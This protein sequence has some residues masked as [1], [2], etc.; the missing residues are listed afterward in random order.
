MGMAFAFGWT[1]CIGPVL[2]AVL[3]LASDTHTLA[4]GEA[5]LVAYSLGLGVPFV[6]LGVAFGRLAGV[7]AFVRAHL[8]IINLVSGLL[9]AGLGILLVTG[10]VARAVQLGIGRPR[11]HRPRQPPHRLKPQ[12]ANGESPRALATVLAALMDLTIHFRNAVALVGRF[13]VLAGVDLDVA[14]GE[15]VLLQ[16]ANGAGKTSLLRACA[17]LLRV[18]AGEAVVLGEDLVRDPR[19]VRRRVGLLGPRHRPLRRPAPGRQPAVRRC[20]P[21]GASAGR[22]RPPW[23]GWASRGGWRRPLSA[24]C[25]PG[26]AGGWPS[27]RWSLA[28]RS[29]GCS[30]SRTPA[31]TPSTGTCWTG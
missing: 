8:R 24:R 12:V 31:S 20:G 5:M 4:R 2:A 16:G 30:T 19:A 7:L 6:A 23:S 22:S 1:P 28:T 29:C 15:I 21:P 3:G 25:P 14:R 10:R 18:V 26:S 17:G 11:R 13:P 9:L 27:P